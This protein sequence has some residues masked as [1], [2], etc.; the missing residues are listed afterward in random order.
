MDASEFRNDFFAVMMRKV[1]Y[2]TNQIGYLRS[3][4]VEERLF[5]FLEEQYGRSSKII[6][7]VSK[8]EIASAIGTKP[9]TLSRLFVRLKGEGKLHWEGREIR[10]SPDAW[11]DT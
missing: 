4:D 11:V 1:R 10:V 8:K 9:E 5:L 7:Q 3:Y 6:P 2:L